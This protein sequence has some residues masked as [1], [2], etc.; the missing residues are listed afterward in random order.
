[1]NT[2]SYSER[3]NKVLSYIGK[4]LDEDLSLDDLSRVSCFSKFHFHRLF[5]AYTGMSLHQYIRWLRL[6][7]AAHQLSSRHSNETILMIALNAGFESN[8]SFSR[9]FKKT[10][11]LTPKDFRKNPLWEKW[12][13][14]KYRVPTEDSTMQVTIQKKNAQRLA[15][16]EHTG[17]PSQLGKSIKQ[18]HDWANKN[19]S[20]NGVQAGKAFGFAYDDPDN[21][22]PEQFRFDLG[23]VIPERIEISSP[24]VERELPEGRYAVAIHKGSRDR[25]GETVYSMYREWLPNSQEELQDLP[26]IFCYKNFEQDIAETELV[27]ECWLLLKN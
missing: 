20:P 4:Y 8:E 13:N 27:T 14:H 3:I 16:F 1:M 11:G 15:V 21:T 23:I 9:A 10:C 12:K 5:S 19:L 26:C 7:R 6:K 24:M 17:N 18:V 22:A 25:L 2:M